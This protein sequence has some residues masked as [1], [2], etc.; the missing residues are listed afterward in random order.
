M[1]NHLAAALCRAVRALALALL[2]CVT[3]GALRLGG[4][5]AE[6]EDP[7][8]V[9]VPIADVQEIIVDVPIVDIQETNVS[10]AADA[11]VRAA[12][13]AAHAAGPE[14]VGILEGGPNIAAY[15][16]QNA[17]GDNDFYLTHDVTRAH[18]DNGCA[19]LD[20][21]A[22]LTPRSQHLMIHGHNMRSGAV[23]GELDAYTNLSYLRQHPLFYWTTDQGME[24]YVPYA[25]ATISVD[26]DSSGYFDMTCF[27]FEDETLFKEFTDG[28]ISRSM[29]EL[30]IDVNYGDQILSLVTCEYTHNNGRLVVALRKLRDD[31]TEESILQLFQ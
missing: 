23:F 5:L 15:I 12:M 9:D 17:D 8:I 1:T 18:N 14:V 28:L 21:R 13:E 22:S 7:V 24:V 16:P 31:E 10:D 4:A 29:V 25:V 3:L 26:P 6:S 20:T 2:I 27:D 11:Q 19:F 30:P